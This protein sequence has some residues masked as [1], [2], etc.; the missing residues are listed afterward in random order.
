MTEREAELPA[1]AK[2]IRKH[3]VHRSHPRLAAPTTAAVSHREATKRLKLLR[4]EAGQSQQQAVAALW[5]QLRGA[6]AR[7]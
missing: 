4:I 6:K 5:A 7:H 2:F 1:V 3:G